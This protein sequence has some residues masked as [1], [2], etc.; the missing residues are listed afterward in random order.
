MCTSMVGNFIAKK[1]ADKVFKLMANEKLDKKKLK[2]INYIYKNESKK[3]F[4]KKLKPFP[5]LAKFLEKQNIEIAI[6]SNSDYNFINNQLIKSNLKKYF[7]SKNIISC[8]KILKAKPKPDGYIKAIKQLKK[9]INNIVV[10]E[11][12]ENGITAAKKANISKIL[13]FTNCNLNISKK[14]IHKDVKNL[15][16]YKEL[17]K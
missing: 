4:K 1:I 6:V 11:D 3:I 16:S 15:K 7:K 10:I 17:L 14:I 8:S 9:N 2:K 5:Y 13:R 12:S